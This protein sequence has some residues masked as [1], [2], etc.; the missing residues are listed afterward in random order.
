MV[1]YLVRTFISKSQES[2]SLR[3]QRRNLID[4]IKKGDDGPLASS[5]ALNDM[6]CFSEP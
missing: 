6:L 1:F 4:L 2:S 3:K 5:V